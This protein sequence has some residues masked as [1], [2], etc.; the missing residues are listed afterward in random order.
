[1]THKA[2]AAV[3][4]LQMFMRRQHG[5]NL[6]FG[7]ATT[8]GSGVGL[9]RPALGASSLRS[10]TPR[11]GTETSFNVIES[12]SAVIG[13]HLH[14]PTEIP[15]VAGVSVMLAERA[16]AKRPFAVIWR[17]TSLRCIDRPQTWVKPRKSNVVA[18][19]I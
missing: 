16:R 2:P 9:A 13:F 3:F 6:R 14:R 17:T 15:K 7:L 11:A 8:S 19:A 1:M 10:S 5:G 4:G 18:D 12:L